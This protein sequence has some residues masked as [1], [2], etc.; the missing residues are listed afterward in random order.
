MLSGRW[1]PDLEGRLYAH[2]G[3]IRRGILGP[4]SLAR[5]PFRKLCHELACSYVEPPRGR[6]VDGELGTV[7]VVPEGAVVTEVVLV[8]AAHG[9]IRGTPLAE[10]SGAAT[11][12]G[13]LQ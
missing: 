5:N 9:P 3:L 10:V 13:A 2:F 12:Q 6:H 7:Y 1:G 4:K 11:S 8:S